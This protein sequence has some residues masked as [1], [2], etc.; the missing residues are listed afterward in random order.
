MNH[1]LWCALG[2]I[3]D[4]LI[5]SA[6][7]SKVKN[8]YRQEKQDRR[9]RWLTYT[10]IAACLVLVICSAI[11]ATLSPT[12]GEVPKD[13]VPKSGVP[14]YDAQLE[15]LCTNGKL[16]F[17]RIATTPRVRADLPSYEGDGRVVKEFTDRHD[18]ISALFRAMDG[19]EAIHA[20]EFV[21]NYQLLLSGQHEDE[22]WHYLIEISDDGMVSVSNNGEPIGLIQISGEELQSIL[23]TLDG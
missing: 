16:V 13:G 19:K 7:E 9:S 5:C 8:Y 20:I 18:I 22:P 11:T 23:K 4:D 17:S 1:D 6:D 10:G 14:P 3:G 21:P 15:I 2:Q 12:K